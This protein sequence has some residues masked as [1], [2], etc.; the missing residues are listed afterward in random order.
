MKHSNRTGPQKV[1]LRIFMSYLHKINTQQKYRISLS[2]D[3]I[4]ETNELI[5]IKF[6]I[7][8]T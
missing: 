7:M 4:S 1:S 3:F 8:Y 2:A 6:C 5:Q